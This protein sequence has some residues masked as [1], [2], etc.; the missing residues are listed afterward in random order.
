R[1]TS[2]VFVTHDLGVLRSVAD[3]VVIMERGAVRESGAAEDVLLRP[4]DSYTRELLA[5]VPD[6][7]SQAA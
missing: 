4:R 6:P 1:Q 7:A 2:I 5:A 3:D